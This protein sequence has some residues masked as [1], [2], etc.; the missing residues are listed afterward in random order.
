MI[1]GLV[2]AYPNL[3]KRLP[4]TNV[5]VRTDAPAEGKVGIV[6][7]GGSGHE[8]AMQVMWEKEC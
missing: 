6:S 2:T 1:T 8:P 5:V 3:L 4:N 7:G